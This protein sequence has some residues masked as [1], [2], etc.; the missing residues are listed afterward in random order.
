MMAHRQRTKLGQDKRRKH[1]HFV[2]KI[3]YRDGEVF[4]RRYTDHDKAV[5]FTDRQRKSPVVKSARVTQ[6]S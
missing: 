4:A 2:A 3:F 5:A 6:I 1:H